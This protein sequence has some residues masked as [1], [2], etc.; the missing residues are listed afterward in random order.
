MRVLISD[1]MDPRCAQIIESNSGFSV[2][3]KTNLNPEELVAAIGDYEAL[4]VRS[5]TQVTDQVLQAGKKLRVIGRAGVG[6]D[7]IDVEAARRS[8]VIVM[9]TPGGNAISTAEHSFAMLIA[10]ARNIPQATA[11]IKA[12][13]W[14][15]SRYTGV[16]LI[17]KSLGV[18]GLGKVGREVAMRASAFGMKVLGH[19]P[20]VSE[21]LAQSYGAHPAMPA[22]IFPQA[23]FI[24]LH[25]HLSP[26]TRH[27]IGAQQLAQCKDG[28]FLVNCARGGLVEEGA[29][30]Q[31]LDSGKVGG[32]ALDVFEE[33]PP[34]RR[35]LVEH[36]RVICTPHLAASTRE[37][38]ANVALQVAEQVGDLL[39]D[40]VIRNAV[41]VPSVDQDIYRI[42]QPYLVLGERMGKFLA[43]IN[44][45][46]LEKI[47]VEYRGDISAY[48]TSPMTSSVLMG[49]MQTVSDE[50][51]NFVNAPVFAQERG[52]AVDELKSSEHE[53]FASLI[54][55][56]YQ[57]T[58]GVRTLAGTI[59]GK[60]DPRFVR[61][62]EYLFDVVPDGHLLIYLNKDI[63]GIIGRIGTIMGSHEV[64]IA[65]MTCGRHQ[66]GG[67]AL[68]ILNVDSE[69]PQTVVDELET[70]HNISWAKKVSL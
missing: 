66:V 32:A 51:V 49:I 38:Q 3:V 11:S 21:E 13:E 2:D 53:D 5:S 31:A 69:I 17:G 65:Q 42:I 10:L 58:T 45:G 59:F 15:R 54:T 30:L 55:V 64:N 60:S 44:E 47:S 67:M 20:F 63:P 8:G 61:L 68:T 6:V 1:K 52:V 12:G 14:D 37:A 7:N 39:T 46:Q 56:V 36:E 70:E 16:E 43:Q 28:V 33:E 34:T 19:D 18:F 27:L 35:E 41:N 23:D 57:T 9:N 48:P 29:L 25:L 62:D 50:A 24:T 22:E 26:Q 40:K 4:I